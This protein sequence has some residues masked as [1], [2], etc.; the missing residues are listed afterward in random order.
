MAGIRSSTP[1]WIW[2]RKKFYSFWVTVIWNYQALLKV[3]STTWFGIPFGIEVILLLCVEKKSSPSWFWIFYP[4]QVSYVS[5]VL[6]KKIREKKIRECEEKRLPLVWFFDICGLQFG[7]V[8]EV[9]LLLGFGCAVWWFAL[10]WYV[11]TFGFALWPSLWFVRNSYLVFVN[12]WFFVLYLSE[13]DIW[14]Y[15]I[16]GF[17]RVHLHQFVLSQI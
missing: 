17:V 12:L 2:I 6:L 1:C 7:I 5:I 10:S 11:A 4:T 8:R 13:R 3:L 16:F 9:L 14:V 15:L